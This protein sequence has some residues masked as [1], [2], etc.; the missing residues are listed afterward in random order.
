MARKI[1]V[2]DF[3]TP[4]G[5]TKLYR[6]FAGVDFSSDETQ[7]DDGRSPWAVN[8]IA[9]EGGFPEKRV[10][11]RTVWQYDGCVHG[12]FPFEQ[13]GAEV[14]IIHAGTTIYQQAGDTRTVLLENVD[15]T[16]TSGFYMN[17]K[18]Y[19]LT[20]SRY[21]VYDGTL[22]QDVTD[23]AHVPTTTYGRAP[24]GGGKAYE[25]VNLLSKYRKNLFCADGTSTAYQL[26]VTN[27]D[28]DVLPTA[29]VNGVSAAVASVNYT[30]GVVS[31]GGAPPAPSTAGVDN[32]EITFAK[33]AAGK[34]Q[35]LGC[36][37]FAAFGIGSDNRVF[38]S[39][40][41]DHPNYEWYSGLADPTYFPDQ[42]YVR[43]GSDAFPIQSYLKANGELF[44]IKEDNRQEG[45]I[46]VHS[47]ELASDGTATF[48]LKEGVSGYGA[49]ARHSACTVMDDPM[50]LSPRGVLAPVT[51]YNYTYMQRSIKNRSQRVNLRLTKETDLAEAVA[52][53]W[54]GW[55][56]LVVGGH[57]YVA[58]TTQKKSEDGYEWYYWTNIPAY[59]LRSYRQ[60]LY[61]GTADGRVCRF[62]DDLVKDDNTIRMMAFND[63]GAAISAEWATK[64]D[65]MDNP[66]RLKTLPKRGSGVHMKAYV[67][68]KIGIYVRTESEA[69]AKLKK[70]AYADR[71]DFSDLDFTRF[72]FNSSSNNMI[73]LQCK[74]K[75]WKAMQIIVKNSEVNEGFGVH[76]IVIRY[77]YGNYA[78]K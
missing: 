61:F 40:N 18:L 29:T 9:D 17:S 76:S 14:F 25:K 64:L 15:G 43:V 53:A 78:K 57:A 42:N 11:W 33:T 34:E 73:P 47:A 74:I 20:G 23:N 8:L 65:T 5:G 36:T 37:I 28:S 21:L 7:I 4:Q 39:G 46:W 56:V 35:I 77:F 22:L 69:Q 50:F 45:T 63:D 44:V 41:S 70:T 75:K 10:G 38:V 60:T 19:L 31:F 51:T 62:N 48:P 58:D 3:G 26:D 24:S 6:R 59:V 66:L 49:A 68:S 12:I 71:L 30:T 13:D 52:A 1:A 54:K 72:T 16:R 27:I 67:R 2:P 55:Y 32:V